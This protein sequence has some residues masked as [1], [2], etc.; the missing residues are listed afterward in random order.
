M[1]AIVSEYITCV[2]EAAM[3]MFFCI[4]VVKD[5]LTIRRPALLPFC[6]GGSGPY[7]QRAEYGH[8]GGA[9]PLDSLL[10]GL[11]HAHTAALVYRGLFLPAGR[12]P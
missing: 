8:G 2:V 5:R 1:E 3:T 7:R 10:A 12:D 11:Q 9:Q 4:Y 6:G